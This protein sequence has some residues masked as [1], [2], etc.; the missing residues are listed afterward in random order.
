MPLYH[1]EYS[2][3]DT[4][5]HEMFFS[6]SPILAYSLQLLCTGQL[7]FN[8]CSFKVS[9]I[10]NCFVDI[11]GNL[12]Y[13]NTSNRQQDVKSVTLIWKLSKK[14]AWMIN[15]N[16]SLNSMKFL[17]IW[18]WTSPC[19]YNRPL[20]CSQ[21]PAKWQAQYSKA[22]RLQNAVH[23]PHTP[24][25]NS[26]LSHIS[27]SSTYFTPSIADDTLSFA[28]PV[29]IVTLSR[30]RHKARRMMCSCDAPSVT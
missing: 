7:I 27:K 5:L 24:S 6:Q 26:S 9:K 2:E 29:G 3:L 8:P 16:Y 20:S 14:L 12:K 18:L 21:Q 4:W 13:F 10:V 1:G 28:L 17:V 23:F 22:T 11:L 19:G 30:C 15:R 25:N